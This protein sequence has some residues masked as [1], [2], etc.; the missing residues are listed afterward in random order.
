[1]R[2]SFDRVK[3]VLYALF[4]GVGGRRTDTGFDFLVEF[5]ELVFDVGLCLAANGAADALAF[6]REAERDRAD[7]ALVGPVSRDAVVT[8]VAVTLLRFGRLGLIGHKA[9]A[10]FQG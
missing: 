7:K 2:I 10:P 8:V 5:V 9:S 3:P 4:D 6:G 1:V